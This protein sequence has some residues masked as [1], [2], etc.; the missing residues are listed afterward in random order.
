MLRETQPEMFMRVLAQLVEN[1][2]KRHKTRLRAMHKAH[3][4][5]YKQAF[6]AD[7]CDDI[8]RTAAWTMRNM[9]AAYET[10]AQAWDE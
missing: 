6:A 5:R 1:E 4:E 2:R 8:A 7:D 10:E 3:A 9:E